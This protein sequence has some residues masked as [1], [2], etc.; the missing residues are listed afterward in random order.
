MSSAYLAHAHSINLIAIG[1]YWL[2]R[3]LQ[4]ITYISPF[5]HDLVVIKETLTKIYNKDH[6]TISVA[7]EELMYF[8]LNKEW[9]EIGNF[10]WILE[11][12]QLAQR[13][14][15][16]LHFCEM[17]NML[18]L[19][20]LNVLDRVK[21]TV[22]PKLHFVAQGQ[23]I[24]GQLGFVFFFEQECR[25]PNAENFVCALVSNGIYAS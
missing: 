13:F 17:R 16:Y 4:D 21:N 18:T 23:H 10:S 2:E 12:V 11:H 15:S 24:Y 19:K 7:L 3:L 22:R 25:Y 6:T 20:G 9:P 8:R 1:R 5:E 14:G